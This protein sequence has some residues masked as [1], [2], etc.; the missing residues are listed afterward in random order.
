MSKAGRRKRKKVHN[1]VLVAVI[2]VLESS[3]NHK[4]PHEAIAVILVAENCCTSQ[5]TISMAVIPY[6]SPPLKFGDRFHI[7]D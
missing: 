4:G 7:R 2:S 3:S 6:S 1:T 5:D